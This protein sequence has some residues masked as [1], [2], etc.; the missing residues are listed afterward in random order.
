MGVS[1]TRSDDVDK[2]NGQWKKLITM[3][4]IAAMALAVEIAIGWDQYS[5]KQT[6]TQ[7][8][9]QPAK[10]T[11][12]QNLISEVNLIEEWKFDCGID[13][14]S[15]VGPFIFVFQLEID[16][17]TGSD[18]ILFVF[19][20]NRGV[21][22]LNTGVLVLC[23][24]TLVHSWYSAGTLLVLCYPTSTQG[25]EVTKKSCHW[26]SSD[27]HTCHVYIDM[28]TIYI[29]ANNI[30]WTDNK[31]S[32]RC[33]ECMLCKRFGFPCQLAILL[34]MYC[35]F[36]NMIQWTE[37]V[38]DHQNNSYFNTCFFLHKT[39]TPKPHVE[40]VQGH[41]ERTWGGALRCVMNYGL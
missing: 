8:N 32:E 38:I 30:H 7:F 13:I 40:W 36:H 18:S 24:Y 39:E 3:A 41:I 10:K 27:N 15:A 9:I 28:Y 21:L 5:C 1:L 19:N 11:W 37:R 33:F 14:Y 2:C 12:N 35:Y 6:A 4:A 22:V 20:N 29:C 17:D 23:W 25:S 34:I 31:L 16:I 26:Q